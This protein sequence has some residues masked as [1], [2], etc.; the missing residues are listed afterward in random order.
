MTDTTTEAPAR[1]TASCTRDLA[2]ARI[3]ATALPAPQ[4]V[5]TAS[6]VRHG[7][8]DPEPYLLGAARMGV[9]PGACLVVEDAAS[10]VASGRAAGCRTLGVLSGQT[11]NELD[12]DLVFPSLADVRFESRPDGVWLFAATARPHS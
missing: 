7:K 5:V 12:A 11:E 4:V 6:D 8:P 3:A 9:E 2:V 10:G 1:Q